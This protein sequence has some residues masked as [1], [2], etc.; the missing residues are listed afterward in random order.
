MQRFKSPR[1]AQ[2][3]LSAQGFIYGHCRPRRHLMSAR[4]YR[5]IRAT[6]FKVRRLDTCAQYRSVASAAVS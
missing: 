1:Q 2:D 5:K 6:D 3:F 4:T